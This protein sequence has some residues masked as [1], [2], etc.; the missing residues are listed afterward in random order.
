MNSTLLPLDRQLAAVRFVLGPVQTNSYLLGD[1]SQKVAVVID[2]AW[3][4]DVIVRKA[5]DLGWRVSGIWLTHAHFDHIAGTAAVADAVG[6]DV[7]IALHSDDL[8]LWHFKGGAPLFGVE[9]LGP[10]LEPSMALSHGWSLW[11]GGHSFEV[12]HT[13]GHTPGHVVFVAHEAHAVFC[14]DLISNMGVGRTDLPGGSWET[15]LNSI[16]TQIMTLSDDTR[17][18]PGHGPESTVGDER[19]S[20]PFLNDF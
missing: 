18:F 6:G 16:R 15:L 2:P 9:Y 14:G 1:Q 17:L 13:P 3:S 19:R 8:P 5:R 11:V 7:P 12:R 4:G 10:G 20:N